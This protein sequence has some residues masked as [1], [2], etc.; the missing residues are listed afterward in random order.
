MTQNLHKNRF[1]TAEKVRR[2]DNLQ[3]CAHPKRL[4]SVPQLHCSDGYFLPTLH[5]RV[6]ETKKK[7]YSKDVNK[8]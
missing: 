3:T 1:L 2:E 6:L 5:Y 8:L 7:S 4:V